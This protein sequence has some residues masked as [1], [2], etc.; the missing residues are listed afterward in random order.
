MCRLSADQ[1]TL[2]KAPQR[3]CAGC[4]A[5]LNK[6]PAGTSVQRNS[7]LAADGQVGEDSGTEVYSSEG[8][9]E[10]HEVAGDASGQQRSAPSGSQFVTSDDGATLHYI[11]RGTGTK[12]ILFI[13]GWLSSLMSWAE[14]IAYFETE[15]T[16]VAYDR[17]G[18]GKSGHASAPGVGHSCEQQ[19]ADAAIVARA[20]GLTNAYVVAHAG[21]CP[22]ACALTREAPSLVQKL[23]LIDGVVYSSIEDV[24]TD[25]NLSFPMFV[26]MVK[27]SNYQQA[28]RAFYSSMFG[29]LLA[30]PSHPKGAMC[31]QFVS[32]AATCE[33]EVALAELEC[34]S[35]ATSVFTSEFRYLNYN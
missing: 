32:D 35:Y 15:Y 2:F 30:E 18:C 23:I 34:V 31:E 28:I 17:R 16:C 19:A 7:A 4:Y 25:P 27:S 5:K 8:E 14:Q 11:V 26:D 9:F 3:S 10:E 33:Q 22:I 24:M 29:N 6:Q 13:H 1:G 21:G 20:A 12:A